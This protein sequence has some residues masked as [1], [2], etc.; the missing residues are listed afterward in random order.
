[1]NVMMRLQP[2]V[3]VPAMR[4]GET[5][6]DFDALLMPIFNSQY[7][8]NQAYFVAGVVRQHVKS[9]AQAEKLLHCY[10]GFL[11]AEMQNNPGVF[12]PVD[13]VDDVNREIDTWNLAFSLLMQQGKIMRPGFPYTPEQQSWLAQALKNRLVE[14]SDRLVQQYSVK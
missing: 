1:M 6:P 13:L 7:S 4:F 8:H 14:L 3:L 9:Q 5:E 11:K 2:R 12:R 10:A